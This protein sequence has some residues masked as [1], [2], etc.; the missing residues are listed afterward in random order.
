MRIVGAA[1][2]V[3]FLLLAMPLS[4]ALVEALVPR[5]LEQGIQIPSV[6]P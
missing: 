3:L 2:A 1:A 5:L 4:R 6:L